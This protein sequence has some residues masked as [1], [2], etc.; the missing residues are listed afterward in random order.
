MNKSAGVF[1]LFALVLSSVAGKANSNLV[2]DLCNHSYDPN[3]CLSSIQAR[4]DSGDFASTTNQ[5]EIV[6]ISA[7]SANASATSAYIKEKLSRK[8]LDPA[9]PWNS[10]TIRSRR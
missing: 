10:L 8:D 2:S 3:L 5:I 7:A 6:A 9:T 1:F 4:L